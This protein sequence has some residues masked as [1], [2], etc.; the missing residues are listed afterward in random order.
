MSRKS[1]TFETF[2]AAIIQSQDTRTEPGHRERSNRKL[3]SIVMEYLEII[4]NIWSLQADTKYRIS[5]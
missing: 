1:V 3:N 5:Y 2:S 4:T